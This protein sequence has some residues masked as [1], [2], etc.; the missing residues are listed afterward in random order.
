MELTLITTLL[1]L[2]FIALHKFTQNEWHKEQ[3]RKR[4]PTKHK[5]PNRY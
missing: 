2:Y 5:A 1:T 4:H 3:A